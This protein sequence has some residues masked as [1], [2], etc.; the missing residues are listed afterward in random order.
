M[1]AIDAAID[2]DDATRDFIVNAW[3]ADPEPLLRHLA[4]TAANL[5]EKIGSDH[6]VSARAVIQAA[7]TGIGAAEE[8][9]RNV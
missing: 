6:G 9:A 4:A 1:A 7:R 8:V 5:A 3:L 2:H